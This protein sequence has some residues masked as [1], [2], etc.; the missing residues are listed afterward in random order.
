MEFKM[1]DDF[2]SGRALIQTACTLRDLYNLENGN[3]GLLKFKSQSLKDEYL[4]AWAIA[5]EYLTRNGIEISLKYIL[6]HR[7]DIDF[8]RKLA[9]KDY[10]NIY[11]LWNLTPSEYRESIVSQLDYTSDEIQ[12]CLEKFDNLSRNILYGGIEYPIDP[13]G[14]SYLML[15]HFAEQIAETIPKLERT[16]PSSWRFTGH[17]EK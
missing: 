3:D 14:S 13:K 15:L 12:E 11:K 8:K 4:A 9:Q 17:I 2:Y 1:T 16:E 5:E 10:H 6:V 7:Y